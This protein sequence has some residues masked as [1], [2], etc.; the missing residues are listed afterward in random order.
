MIMEAVHTAVLKKKALFFPV[1]NH[2]LNVYAMGMIIT[3]PIL[4]NS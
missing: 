2:N 3:E 4:P 1:N